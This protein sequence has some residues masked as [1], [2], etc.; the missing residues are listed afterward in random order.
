MEEYLDSV[1]CD[2]QFF[3]VNLLLVF[4]PV[5]LLIFSFVFFLATLSPRVQGEGRGQKVAQGLRHGAVPLGLGLGILVAATMSL[6]DAFWDEV[7]FFLFF[8][9][10]SLPPTPSHFSPPSFRK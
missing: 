8:L 7:F 6:L 9:S 4:F 3:F 5:L 2:A 1:K 10:L